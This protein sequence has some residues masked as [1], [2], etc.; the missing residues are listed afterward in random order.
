MKATE[1]LRRYAAGERDFRGA[2]LRGQNF[3]G[4]DLSGADFSGAD[5]RSTNFTKAILTGC[6]FSG[7]KAGLQKRSTFFLVMTSWIIS[8]FAGF[9]AAF[10]GTIVSLI[11][12]SDSTQVVAGAVMLLIFFS[13][14][15]ALVQQGASENTSAIATASVFA[16]IVTFAFI[17]AD[18]GIFAVIVTSLASL[19]IAGMAAFTVAFT[20]SG[21][22]AGILA[23]AV[24]LIVV[25]A[26]AYLGW[27]AL[28]GDPRDA[29]IRSVA[30]GFAAI[31][32]TSFRDADLT[33]ACFAQARLKSTD[34]RQ[35]TIPCTNWHLAKW[36]DRA[37]VGGTIL[38]NPQVR[39]LC[40]THRGAKQ[41][42]VGCDLKGANLAGADLD[43][44]DLTEADISGATLQDATLERA[45]LTKTQALGTEFTGAQ[46]TGACLEEWNIGSTTQLKGVLCDYVYLL[47]NQQER[48]P[49]S[50]NFQPGE[51]TKLFEEV[52]DT[53]DLIFR[54]GLDWQAFATSFQQVLV[55]N[56]GT[57]LAIQSI[58]NKGDGVV[59]VKVQA[60]PDANKEKIHSD[61]MRGYKEAEK[62]LEAEHQAELKGKDGQLEQY[63]QE[64]S[65]LWNIV[66][67]MAN[68]SPTVQNF[69]G[70]V[71]SVDNKGNIG[72]AAGEAGGNQQQRTGDE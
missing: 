68:R 28:K 20:F 35:A 69:E 63:R 14:L 53:I 70:P 1:V 39:E 60:S 62:V 72:N 26:S 31:G 6:N 37:R 48:R 19:I 52:L 43:D 13:L 17:F 55:E 44:A 27:R 34:L 66:N 71:G 22:S 5:V 23:V 45:N 57:E 36:L 11:F 2:N 25:V 9:L 56:D 38:L 16:I 18:V 4:R 40:V 54:N 46:L 10:A 29:W 51:F 59:V 41:S 15:I 65:N 32:G 47:R 50:G 24:V 42:Y 3:K 8:I 49:S 12:S 58:E 21:L 7:A 64:V 33:G 30:I 67:V 61:F